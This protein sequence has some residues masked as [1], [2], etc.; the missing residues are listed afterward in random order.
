MVYESPSLRNYNA[1]I[2]LIHFTHFEVCLEFHSFSVTTNHQ[3]SQ[4]TESNLLRFLSYKG[5]CKI[6][7]CSS[8]FPSQALQKW[9]RISSKSDCLNHKNSDM[10]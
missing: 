2:R 3:I 10:T 5:K 4:V 7:H 1:K 8:V 6:I 9:V